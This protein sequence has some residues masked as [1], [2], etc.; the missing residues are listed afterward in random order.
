MRKAEKNAGGAAY[1]AK[2]DSQHHKRKKKYSG[3]QYSMIKAVSLS[4]QNFRIFSLPPK[5]LLSHSQFPP[6]AT[7]VH[8]YLPMVYHVVFYDLILSFSMFSRFIH[9]ESLSN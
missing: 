4:Q 2:F 9:V 3:C 7:S 6:Q 8:I 1:V 5:K